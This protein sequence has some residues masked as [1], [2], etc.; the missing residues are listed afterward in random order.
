ML[1]RCEDNHLESHQSRNKIW[2]MYIMNTKPCNQYESMQPC[3]QYETM[4]PC[5][6]IW[7]C[8]PTNTVQFI[9][10]SCIHKLHLETVPLQL[11]IL[12]LCELTHS[13]RGNQPFC[14]VMQSFNK[15]LFLLCFWYIASL[16]MFAGKTLHHHSIKTLYFSKKTVNP[17]SFEIYTCIATLMRG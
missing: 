6:N 3:N 15:L 13:Q 12:H 17:D 9:G 10:N 2:C 7:M 5:I 4:Q 14:T 16:L 8:K 1:K 11:L